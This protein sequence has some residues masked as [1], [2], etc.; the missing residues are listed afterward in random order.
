MFSQ[1]NPAP[2][3]VASA[4]E[5]GVLPIEGNP[6]DGSM[7]AVITNVEIPDIN[8]EAE[9]AKAQAARQEQKAR[10]EQQAQMAAMQQ[11]MQVHPNYQMQ[12]N[13]QMQQNYHQQQNMQQQNYHQPQNYQAA[14]RHNHQHR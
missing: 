1:T 11:Q 9:I 12:Q 7:P 6:A 5:N 13:M 3:V 14:G 8:M 2:N 10:E 4:D